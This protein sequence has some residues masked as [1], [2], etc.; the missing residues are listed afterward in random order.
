M[1]VA[2]AIAALARPTA[3]GW[4]ARLATNQKANPRMVVTAH[5]ATI[6][7]VVEMIRWLFRSAPPAFRMESMPDRPPCA[8]SATGG[9]DAPAGPG[10]G[11]GGTSDMRG[12]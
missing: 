1:R 2:A 7:P 6:S 3:C 12:A 4:N 11:S 5:D 10:T 9:S 8:V